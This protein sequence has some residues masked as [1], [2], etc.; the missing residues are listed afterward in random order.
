MKFGFEAVINTGLKI[1][2]LMICFGFA[3][4]LFFKLIQVCS[5]HLRK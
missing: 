1:I 3:L 5:Q 4:F 2:E